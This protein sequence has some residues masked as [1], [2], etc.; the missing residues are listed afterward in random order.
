MRLTILGMNGPYPAPGSACSGYFIQS[1]ETRVQFDLG[2]GTLAALTALTPPEHLHAL[3]F[4][5]W[6]FDHCSDA[7][8]LMFRL[9]DV[10][11]E[12]KLDVYGP[13][14]ETSMVRAALGKCQQVRLHDLH[15]GETVALGG[16]TLKTWAA[17]HPVPA[18]ML[19]LEDGTSTLC[20]TGDTN[21]VPWLKEF[22][23]KADLL[24]AD[25]LFPAEKWEAGKPHLSAAMAAQL[26]V[27]VQA[28]QLVVTH[29]NPSIDPEGLLAQARA[30]RRD[31]KLARCG[32]VYEC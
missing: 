7:L 4:S 16:I 18:L 21:A 30:I 5:H 9:A 13:V 17:K 22:A 27:D 24:L 23:D 29:L 15:A 10:M 2:C 26:A 11:P 20:Y 31:A 8:P 3:V 12:G 28:R 1:G 32:D 6:H 14:D 19:R 25:G